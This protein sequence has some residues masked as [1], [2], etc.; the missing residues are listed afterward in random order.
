VMGEFGISGRR[1]FRKDIDGIR[2]FQVHAFQIGSDEIARHLAFRDYLTA[3]T[4]EARTYS[5]LKVRLIARYDGNPD[6]YINGKEEFIKEIDRKAAL[7]RT[8]N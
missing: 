4:D 6:D 3:H 2:T 5:E 1:Y 8:Q 7:W